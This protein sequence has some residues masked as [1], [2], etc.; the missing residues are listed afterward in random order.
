MLNELVNSYSL[1][2]VQAYMGHIKAN[3]DVAVRS[4]L[5]ETGERTFKETGK[6]ILKAEDYMDDGTKI[7][8][9]VHIET[10]DVSQ[11]FIFLLF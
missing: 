2:V 5:K 6:S 8:L 7:A 1:P 10:K 9:A 4:L 3:A 11:Y